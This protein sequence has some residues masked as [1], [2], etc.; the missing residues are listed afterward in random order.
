MF[1]CH[2]ENLLVNLKQMDSV[3]PGPRSEVCKTC[4]ERTVAQLL[5]ESSPNLEVQAEPQ[6]CTLASSAF[7]GIFSAAEVT[8]KEARK[9]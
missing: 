3:S 1:L 5:R 8:R 7:T 2:K 4:K 9:H 6:F